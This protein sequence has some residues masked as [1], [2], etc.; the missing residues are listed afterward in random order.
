[1]DK[2]RLRFEHKIFLEMHML[3]RWLSYLARQ[4]YLN[5]YGYNFSQ[6]AAI[7]GH[8]E[9]SRVTVGIHQCHL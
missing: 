5:R 9:H 4:W 7:E 6:E 3:L 8:P 1:M 2:C